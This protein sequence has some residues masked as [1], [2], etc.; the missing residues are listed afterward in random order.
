MQTDC[1][2][3]PI[4]TF[5]FFSK[6]EVPIKCKP[7]WVCQM[8]AGM[9]PAQL[10]PAG[11]FCNLATVTNQTNSTVEQLYKPNFCYQSSYCLAGVYTPFVNQ[12]NQQAAQSCIAGTFCA[13]GSASP[14]GNGKC[15]EGFYCPAGSID[16]I[17]TE[18][19][20]FAQGTG[21][22]MPEKCRPG[23]FQDKPQ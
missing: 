10:C 6:M 8:K 16:M 5:C 2:M 12:T 19:G 18:P 13:E 20:Y 21:N 22:V 1:E 3:C 23:T 11:S 9:S 14:E 15:K 7:G 17:P 4:G